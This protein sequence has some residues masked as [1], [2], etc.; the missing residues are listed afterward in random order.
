M[1]KIAL[2]LA[3]AITSFQL[4]ASANPFRYETTCY[5]EIQGDVF[6][7]DERCVVIET[8]EKG[9]GLRTRNIF[10][11]KFGLTIK[12][13]W[14]GTKFMT[15]DSHNKFEYHWLYKPNENIREDGIVATY[16]MPSISV[17]NISWD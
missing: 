11:N 13:W 16:V 4:P 15:W 8:R 1:K 3:A 14:D 9:G 10:S 17:M 7:V 12:S 6:K 2:F 5:W